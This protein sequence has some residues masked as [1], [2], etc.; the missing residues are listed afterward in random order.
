MGGWQTALFWALVGGIIGTIINVKKGW[1]GPVGFLGGAL[2]GPV[3]VWLLLLTPENSEGLGNR[4]CP[5]CAE[6]VKKEA[7]VCKH[8]RKDLIPVVE[9][10]TAPNQPPISASPSWHAKVNGGGSKED[11]VGYWVPRIGSLIGLVLLL[12]LLIR[13]RY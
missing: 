5:Y 12:I 1:N 7:S 6:M 4:K 8:C 13:A 11:P 3:L 10:M 2:L 9:E